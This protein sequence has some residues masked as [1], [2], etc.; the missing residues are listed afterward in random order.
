[1]EPSRN[2]RRGRRQACQAAIEW[3]YF[4]QGEF[5]RAVKRNDGRRGFYFESA[6]CPK[7]NAS[8]FVKPCKGHCCPASDAPGVRATALARVKWIKR[9][10]SGDD[11]LY[12]VGAE[13]FD[14][15]LDPLF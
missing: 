13:Y 10:K 11:P 9:I 7:V 4:N 3:M 14:S 1:M 8:I 12:G 15:S 2:Q 6:T 5:Q